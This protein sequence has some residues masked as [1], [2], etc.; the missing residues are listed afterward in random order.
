MDRSFNVGDHKHWLLTLFFF[1]AKKYFR[2]K[3]TCA[4][5]NWEYWHCKE[6]FRKIWLF[7]RLLTIIHCLNNK[8]HLWS[9]SKVPS[10]STTT[11]KFL[12]RC[13]N[14]PM[15]WVKPLSEKRLHSGNRKKDN[16]ARKKNVIFAKIILKNKKKIL[17]SSYQD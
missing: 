13:R 5:H 11:R 7:F 1:C 10:V 12:K 8:T 2:Y 16:T 14:E 17:S 9:R 15:A 4:I 3:S 6:L